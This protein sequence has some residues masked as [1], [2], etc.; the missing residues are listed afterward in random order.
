[1]KMA[2]FGLARSGMSALRHQSSLGEYDCYAVNRGEPSSW[3]NYDEV[4]SLI[5]EANCFSEEDSLSLLAQMDV[6]VKSPGIP[7]IHPALRLAREN[8]VEIISEIEYAFRYSDIPVVAITGTNGKTTTAT[9]IHE[10]LSSLGQK[11]FLG[12]N[13]GIPYSEILMSKDRYDWAVVE[14]SSFQLENIKSFKPRIAILTNISHSH[15]ERYESHELYRDAKLKLFQSM[16]K[17]DTAIVNRDFYGLNLPCSKK[18]IKSLENFDYSK[19]KMVGE[20]NKE[21]L[22]CAYLSAMEIIKDEDRVNKATQAYI[23]SFGGVEYRIQHVATKGNLEIYNDGKSTNMASTLAAVDSVKGKKI[24]LILGGKLRDKSMDFT[25]LSKREF[26]GVYAF[27]ESRDFIKES[28]PDKNVQTYDDLDELFKDLAEC[29]L[30]GVLLFSPAFP[31]FDLFKN[32]EERAKRF[33]A[34]AREL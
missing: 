21:N 1:M 29:D 17:E 26:A 2:I 32:Y 16:T 22:Y 27:G 19:T 7:Y 18:S 30:K 3:E 31:S 11:V 33:N 8:K 12:G 23:D 5:G 20:H 25:E 9:M 15:A 28:L 14:V 13:I 34:L 4:S 24:H 10:L 6:I